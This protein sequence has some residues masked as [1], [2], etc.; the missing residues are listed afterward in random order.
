MS[1]RVQALREGIE[2]ENLLALKL[3]SRIEKA[4]R[5]YESVVTDYPAIPIDKALELAEQA[6]K[7]GNSILISGAYHGVILSVWKDKFE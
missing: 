4:L 7:E 1:D 6:L 2:R 5:G 3:C